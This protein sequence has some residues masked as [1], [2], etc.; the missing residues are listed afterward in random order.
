MDFCLY[1]KYE[2]QMPINLKSEETDRLARALARLTG[3]SLTDA[4]TT[5]VR[6]RLERERQVRR[7]ADT[8]FWAGVSRIQ[9]R[10]AAL[11]VLDGRTPDEI[12]GYDDSGAPG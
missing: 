1:W 9:Q 7:A 3:E 5:A 11:P 12:V 6:E 4:I 2:A 10:V 8:E